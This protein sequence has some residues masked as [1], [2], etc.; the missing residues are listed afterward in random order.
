MNC[1]VGKILAGA[2][3]KASDVSLAFGVALLFAALGIGSDK[4]VLAQSMRSD[5]LVDTLLAVEETYQDWVVTCEFIAQ[6]EAAATEQVCQMRQIIQ[7]DVGQTMISVALQMQ[8]DSSDAM[9][10]L[11]V[12]FGLLVSEPLTV[13]LAQVRLLA[14]DFLTCL[15]RGCIVIAPITRETA[16]Q[17]ASHDMAVIT[18]IMGDGAPLSATLSFKGFADSWNRIQTDITSQIATDA[19]PEIAAISS[20]PVD[21]LGLSGASASETP[22]VQQTDPIP[23]RPFTQVGLFGVEQNARRARDQLQ[24]AGLPN[25]IRRGQSQGRPFWRVLIGPARDTAE[26]ERFLDQARALGFADAYHVRG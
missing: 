12:P 14:L 3:R 9:L 19:I 10:S 15:P 21:T 18:M 16:V 23:E 20:D 6:V 25:D 4:I 1:T 2:A 24:L 11:V 13:D 22:P 5:A 7:A 8:D 26:N 17:M